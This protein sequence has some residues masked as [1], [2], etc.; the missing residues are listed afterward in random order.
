[1]GVYT[2]VKEIM[3]KFM[4]YANNKFNPNNLQM[5]KRGVENPF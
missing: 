3:N 1:M 2:E 5:V 4:E